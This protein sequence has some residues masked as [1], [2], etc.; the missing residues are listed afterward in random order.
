MT[1]IQLFTAI[2]NAIR[3]KTGS[4]ETIKAENFPTEIADITTGHLDN[5][6]YETSIDK[7][8]EILEGT[9]VPT[10]T[11]QISITQNGTTI[12]DVTNYVNAQIT[13]NVVN[14]D[15]EDALVAFG[16]TE[17]LTDGIEALTT[18]SNEITGESDTTLSDA[19]ASLADG[20]GQGGGYTGLEYVINGTD[21]VPISEVIWHGSGK[22]HNS[23]CQGLFGSVSKN[24]PISFPDHPTSVDINS[25]ASSR[26]RI[27]WNTLGAEL[28]TVASNAFRINYIT[29]CS[30]DIVNFPKFTG[31]PYDGITPQACFSYQSAKA[32]ST[33]YFDTMQNIP[34]EIFTNCGISNL[35]VTFGSIGHTVQSAGLY[36]FRN[37]QSTASGTVTTYTT[38]EYL[39][40]IRT[41]IEA[42][43]TVLTFVYKA[44]EAT[45]YN[46]ISYN[47]GDT[48]SI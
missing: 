32:P 1:L 14:Q 46:G 21:T 28:V 25:F 16:V 8:D 13:T 11:K 12:E 29:D 42:G 5:E 7:L 4:S 47:A 27:D 26:L 33:Y 37:P 6:E 17:D 3:A 40:T 36:P 20:Y 30:T 45:T 38:G 10:G 9:E 2:A 31:M 23:C 24:I 35:S 34:R 41:A 48:I 15:Y 39:D 19:V 22:I 43:N 44:S 18:Y